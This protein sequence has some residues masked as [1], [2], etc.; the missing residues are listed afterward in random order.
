MESTPP[1]IWSE[2]FQWLSRQQDYVL[3]IGNEREPA[4]VISQTCCQWRETATEICPFLWSSFSVTLPRTKYPQKRRN[5]AY[6]VDVVLARTGKENLRIDFSGVDVGIYCPASLQIFKRIILYAHRWESVAL[7]LPPNHSHLLDAKRRVLPNL[8]RARISAHPF[9][10]YF[11]FRISGVCPCL[12]QIAFEGLPSHVDILL[13]FHHLTT[14]QDER[15]DLDPFVYELYLLI[16]RNATALDT[17]ATIHG[18][19]SD[20]DLPTANQRIVCN[21]LRALTTSSGSILRSV[22]TPNL[23]TIHVEF[24][25]PE[26][27]TESSCMEEVDHEYGASIEETINAIQSVV[28]VPNPTASSRLTEIHLND[29]GLHAQLTALLQST[30]DLKILSITLSRWTPVYDQIFH[31]LLSLLKC[32]SVNANG[33][34]SLLAIPKLQSLSLQVFDMK[35]AIMLEWVDE[36]LPDVLDMRW[37]NRTDRSLKKAHVEVGV[38][39]HH[40]WVQLNAGR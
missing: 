37:S 5:V 6:V 7:Y 17:F 10:T 9:S 28:V 36:S 2:I 40:D 8:H 16:L 19:T 12:E 29:V 26:T 20:F 4:F 30:L 31:Q 21:T 38:D 39:Q 22:V 23:Q 11:P 35:G 25:D 34:I 18:K 13:P 15:I 1:E 24:Y 3:H 27:D 14:F 32:T 33:S